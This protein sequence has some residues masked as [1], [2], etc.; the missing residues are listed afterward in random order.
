MTCSESDDKDPP[1]APRKQHFHNHNPRSDRV[2]N[3]D[4]ASTVAGFRDCEPRGRK[5]PAQSVLHG[6]IIINDKNSFHVELLRNSFAPTLLG[7]ELLDSDA[8]CKA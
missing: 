1:A 2:K 6:Q 7:A 8:K 5:G 4:C 3:L